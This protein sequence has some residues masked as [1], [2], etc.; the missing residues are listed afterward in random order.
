MKHRHRIVARGYPGEVNPPAF[1]YLLSA[2]PLWKEAL[3]SNRVRGLRRLCADP[4]NPE[5]SGPLALDWAL[6]FDSALSMRDAWSGATL[7]TT[8]E[9]PTAFRG[10]VGIAQGL[11]WIGAELTSARVITQTGGQKIGANGAHCIRFY[12]EQPAIELAE[13]E[14]SAATIWQYRWGAYQLE[15]RAGSLN[16]MRRA[17]TWT[18]AQEDVLHGIERT[19]ESDPAAAD[20]ATALRLQLY[21]E[22]TSVPVSELYGRVHELTFIAEPGPGVLHVFGEEG[23]YASLNHE[24][25]AAKQLRPDDGVGQMWPQCARSMRSKGHIWFAQWGAPDF[26]QIGE[27]WTANIKTGYWAD[28]L[29]DC[30]KSGVWDNSQLGSDVELTTEN[31]NEVFFRIRLKLTGDGTG[32]PLVYHA[33]AVIEPGERTGSD[34]TFWDSDDFLNDDGSTIVRDVSAQFEGARRV[35]TVVLED[36]KGR[37]F[38]AAGGVNHSISEG[39]LIDIYTDGAADVIK[40][41]VTNAVAGPVA[42][43]R[44]NQQ[45]ALVRRFE[46]TITLSVDAGHALLDEA[47]FQVDLVGDGMNGNEWLRLLL[48]CGGYR[49][50]E[51]GRIQTNFESNLGFGDVLPKIESAAWGAEPRERPAIGSKI[52]AYLNDFATDYGLGRELL[53][54]DGWAFEARPKTVAKYNGA[55]I[56]FTQDGNPDTYPGRFQIIQGLEPNRETTE[57]YNIFPVEGAP[58]RDGKPITSEFRVH[59]SI[60][61][62]KWSSLGINNHIGRA[63]RAPVYRKSSLRTLDQAFRAARGYFAR[64]PKTPRINVFETYYHSFLRPYMRIRVDGVLSEIE[65]MPSA[66]SRADRMQLAAREL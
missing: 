26:R 45:L 60:N 58:D 44:T 23:A 14:S 38:S 52:G 63:L 66:S 35:Y 65:R 36:Q 30:I 64:L 18:Q 16:L 62:S 41:L 42:G 6:H 39:R 24:Q 31:V 22:S 10:G 61:P 29:G 47:E 59:E 7:S 37:V 20:Q 2:G 1:S 17:P 57:F 21:A 15:A 34:E 49:Q 55:E 5:S 13:G 28:A 32:T 3:K 27:L 51:L 9:L 43:I 11:G 56:N 46:T 40:G 4:D 53:Y 54:G 25:I 19:G 12:I 8:E 50:S 48:R 33:L